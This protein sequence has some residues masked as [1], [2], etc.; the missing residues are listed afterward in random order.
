VFNGGASY[1]GCNLPIGLG[2]AYN[3]FGYREF[4]TTKTLNK[5]APPFL[6]KPI[7][8]IQFKRS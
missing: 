1:Y 7:T 6:G 4:M 2:Q 8:T 5:E 3:L